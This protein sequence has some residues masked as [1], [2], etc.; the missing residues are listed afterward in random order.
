MSSIKIELDEFQACQLDRLSRK[1]DRS[2]ASLVREALRRQL[3]V[4]LFAELRARA[5]P[6]VEAAGFVTDE[7]VFRDLS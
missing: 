6:Y 4:L 2:R 5:A 7:D 1:T 3:A